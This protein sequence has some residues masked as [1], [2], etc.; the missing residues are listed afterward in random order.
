MS[1]IKIIT[2]S[3][4]AYFNLLI[5]M[6]NSV[7]INFPE[8]NMHIVLVN[9]EEEKDELIRKINPTYEVVHENVDLKGNDLKCYC[10]NRRM[11][12]L[13]DIRGMD[14]SFLIWIDADSLVRK[15]CDELV[16]LSHSCELTMRQKTEKKHAAGVI[17]IGNSNVCK[18]FLNRYSL[19]GE[20]EKDWMSNQR[21]LSNIYK[22][23][24]DRISYKPLP[25]KFCDVWLSDD[26]VIWA[27]KSKLKK[28]EKYIK[29][30]EKYEIQN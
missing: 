9:I 11:F 13:N 1:N 21:N 2:L 27:A 10:T 7:N 25:N 20:I 12:L 19:I 3:D 4:G 22:E 23:F 8:A 6:V 29:E 5:P 14:N 28:S 17:G 15:R 24:K 18:E 30:K 26:G 16:A